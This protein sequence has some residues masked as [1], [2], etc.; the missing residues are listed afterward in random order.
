MATSLKEENPA[1]MLVEISIH[2]EVDSLL[3]GR[4]GIQRHLYA[5]CANT[6]SNNGG[7]ASG[8]GQARLCIK[9]SL[10]KTASSFHF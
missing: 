7:K 10:L 8:G 2:M 6:T 1:E 9:Q 5:A 3:N 4:A